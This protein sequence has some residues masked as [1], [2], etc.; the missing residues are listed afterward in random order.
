MNIEYIFFLSSRLYG[1]C[2]SSRPQMA[3]TIA[4][5]AGHRL[6]PPAGGSWSIPPIVIFLKRITQTPKDEY[7]IPCLRIFVKS[8]AKENYIIYSSLTFASVSSSL[9]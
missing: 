4:C 2:L 6:V 1:R 3:A 5:R 7:K 9:M 8:E